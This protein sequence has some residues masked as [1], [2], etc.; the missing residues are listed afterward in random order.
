MKRNNLIKRCL[1]LVMGI[2]LVWFSVSSYKQGVADFN[3]QAKDAFGKTLEKEL[4]K[5]NLGKSFGMVQHWTNLSKIGEVPPVVFVDRGSGRLEYKMSALKHQLNVAQDVN[6]RLLH[7]TALQ[8]KPLIPDTLNAVWQQTLKTLQTTAETAVRMSVSDGRG[9]TA[10]LLSADCTRFTSSPPLFTCYLGYGSEVELIG[11]ISAPWWY[12]FIHY[13]GAHFLL[14]S[15]I[16]ALIYLFA[17]YL[18][19]KLQPSVVLNEVIVS[20]LVKDLPKGVAHIYQLKENVFFNADQGVLSV[21]GKEIKMRKQA[22]R[23]LEMFLNAENYELSDAAIMEQLWAKGSETA[24]KLQQAISRLRS[25]L[26][27]VPSIQLIRLST[28]SYKLCIDTDYNEVE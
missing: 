24:E 9:H 1:P 15:A 22:G 3:E 4:V 16:G 17:C 5:R 10:T 25:S 19:R 13:A 11:F 12:V 28:Y 21:D 23:L 14:L 20:Q 8:K 27:G 2:G 7:S 26:K 18:I 6:V